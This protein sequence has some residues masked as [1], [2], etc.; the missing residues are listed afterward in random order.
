[1]SVLAVEGRAE[2]SWVFMLGAA[3][4]AVLACCTELRRSEGEPVNWRKSL[5]TLWLVGF[6]GWCG[7]YVAIALFDYAHGSR[8]NYWWVAVYAFAPVLL[9]LAVWHSRGSP[10]GP[11]DEAPRTR[12]AR[13]GCWGLARGIGFAIGVVAVG[14]VAYEVLK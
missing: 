1:M 14:Y 8:G 7:F 12:N 5:F 4:M 2:Y 6:T 10:R 9:G 11:G 13:Q 3:A